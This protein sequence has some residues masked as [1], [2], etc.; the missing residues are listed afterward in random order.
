MELV[1]LLY[2]AGDRAKSWSS[3]L[4][5]K[6]NTKKK[7]KTEQCKRET[8]FSP[9]RKCSRRIYVFVCCSAPWEEQRA[10]KRERIIWGNSSDKRLSLFLQRAKQGRKKKTKKPLRA[11]SAAMVENAVALAALP[12][13]NALSFS[14]QDPYTPYARSSGHFE[15]GVKLFCMCWKCLGIKLPA[16]DP[17][18]WLRTFFDTERFGVLFWGFVFWGFFG[19]VGGK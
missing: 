5:K 16:T 6:K 4:Q 9:T 11:C 14:S 1:E 3:R 8:S 19:G 10:P 17:F 7:P 12:F 2:A 15:H 18:A 13:S